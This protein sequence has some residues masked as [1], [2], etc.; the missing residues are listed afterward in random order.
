MLLALYNKAIEHLTESLQ[1]LDRN[2]TAANILQRTRAAT[3]LVAI[4]SGIVTEYGE[5]PAKIDQLCEYVQLCVADG[6]RERIESA[7]LVMG[8][9]RDGFAGIRDEANQMELGGEIESIP[10]SESTFESIF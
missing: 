5:I 8:K 6:S 9:L 2:D 3:V 1:S 4:R 10:T 7:C